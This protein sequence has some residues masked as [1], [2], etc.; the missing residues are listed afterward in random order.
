MYEG[1][2]QRD[3]QKRAQQAALQAQGQQELMQKQRALLAA[4]PQAQAQTSGSLTGPAGQS[5]VDL[6]A[7]YPSHSGGAQE[8]PS[9]PGT[10]SAPTGQTTQQMGTQEMIA[11]LGQPSSQGNFSG[12]WAPTSQGAYNPWELAPYMNTT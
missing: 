11:K 2:Q 5:F 12:G 9:T 1:S 6:L 7:G 8:Q 3:A 10:P 4:G